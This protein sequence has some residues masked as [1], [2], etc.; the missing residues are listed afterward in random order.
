MC[1][2]CLVSLTLKCSYMTCEMYGTNQIS[3]IARKCAVNV[4]CLPY[5]KTCLPNPKLQDM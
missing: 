4:I 5:P 1:S 3:D 2:K